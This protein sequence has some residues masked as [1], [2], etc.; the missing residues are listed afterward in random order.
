MWINGFSD[1]K[2]TTVTNMCTYEDFKFHQAGT[3]EIIVFSVK[4][5]VCKH[6]VTSKQEIGWCIDVCVGV[7]ITVLQPIP[8]KECIQLQIG[9]H[10][11]IM[12]ESHTFYHPGHYVHMEKSAAF[13]SD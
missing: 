8:A 7:W 5:M 2:N 6:S 12:G 1:F 9:E 3:K 11:Q 4:A 10:F 13:I